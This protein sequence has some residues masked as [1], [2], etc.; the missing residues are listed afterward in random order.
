MACHVNQHTVNAKV[1]NSCYNIIVIYTWFVSAIM[2]LNK[3]YCCLVTCIYHP[4]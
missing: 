3:K 2:K 1:D 4:L